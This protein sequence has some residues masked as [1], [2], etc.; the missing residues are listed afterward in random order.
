MILHP[1]HCGWNDLSE[2]LERPNALLDAKC[3]FITGA[4]SLKIRFCDVNLTNFCTGKE[5]SRREETSV[6]FE[7]RIFAIF[8]QERKIHLP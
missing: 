1:N 7:K 3:K 5:N 2:D 6:Q 8:H 4:N